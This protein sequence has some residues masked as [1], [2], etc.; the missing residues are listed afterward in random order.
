MKRIL[1]TLLIAGLGSVCIAQS[2]NTAA[3]IR[4]GTDWGLTLRQRVYE[5]ISAELMLTSSL[6]RDEGMFTFMGLYH[7]PI[8]IRNLNL[9]LAGGFHLGWTSEERNGLPAKNPVGL[10]VMGGAELTISRVNI[11]WD[12]KPAVNIV[13]GSSTFYAQTGFS[14]R[15]VLWKRDRYDWEPRRRRDSIFRRRR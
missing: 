11:S 10:D 9:Y 7:Q 2:Y 4:I 5:N 6:Q 1:L 13:G 15:Y 14:V 3:G 8:F 12:F